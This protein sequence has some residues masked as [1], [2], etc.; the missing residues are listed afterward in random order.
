MAACPTDGPC[1]TASEALVI[2]AAI[3]MRP[4]HAKLEKLPNNIQED[5]GNTC[6]KPETS[7]KK[8]A[9]H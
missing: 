8:Q 7:L 3:N 2:S 9:I 1:F 5:Q 4:I 6:C